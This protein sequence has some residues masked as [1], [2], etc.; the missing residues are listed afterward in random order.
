MC[1]GADRFQLVCSDEI[2][3]EL[4]RVL[5]RPKIVTL[6]A[7]DHAE[8]F[9]GLVH[10]KALLVELKEIP[11]VSRDPKDDI[12]LACAKEADC[13]LLVSGDKDLRDLK[14]HGQTTIVS[15]RQFLEILDSE[16]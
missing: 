8:A 7:K 16:K 5:R 2:I 9:M 11:A 1:L 10:E 4:V 12:Y 3:D 15:P 14:T 6:I 13:D